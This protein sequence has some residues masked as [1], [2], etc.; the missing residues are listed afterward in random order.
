MA[1]LKKAKDAS[2]ASEISTLSDF[3]L[4]ALEEDVDLDLEIK[5]FSQ[6]MLDN[7]IPAMCRTE[8][9]KFFS[10]MGNVTSL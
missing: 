2:T 8:A 6:E 7:I 5:S 10:L 3:S 9:A 4:T 1:R